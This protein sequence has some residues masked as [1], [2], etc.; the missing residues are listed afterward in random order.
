MAFA[1]A[2]L[3]LCAVAAIAALWPLLSGATVERAGD[4]AREAEIA[5]LKAALAENE[6]DH[7]AGRIT[8]DDAQAARAELGRRL[9]ALTRSEK[10]AATAAPGAARTRRL[11]V[12]AIAAL[13]VPL[14]AIGLYAALGSP[15]LPD[16]PI[17]SR[18]RSPDEMDLPTLIA[19][20]EAHLAENPDDARGWTSLA[21]VYRREGRLA[22]S[23]EA[24]QRA[25]PQL[26]GL[27]RSLALTEIV[28]ITA[29]ETNG[30]DE[31]GQAMLAEAL[32]IAPDNSKADFLL[33][34]AREI[35]A[36]DEERLSEWRAL[37]E[38]H[39]DAPAEWLPLARQRIASLSARLEG[40]ASVEADIARLPARE[41]DAMIADMVDGLAARLANDPDDAEG[42]LRL[43]RSYAV[44]DRR[45]DAREAIA[46]ARA[47]FDGDDAVSGRLAALET[48]LG[49]AGT[50]RA[51]GPS[52]TE[53]TPDERTDEPA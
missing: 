10:E 18:E 44:L 15:A 16:R 4:E 8:F 23:R 27:N 48:E 28:E 24:W 30:I 22:D 17:A 5:T 33:V 49:L 47:T 40:T 45:D 31:R 37:V 13:A 12:P 1:L 43:I 21:P 6:R 26:A 29:I 35:A 34:A 14:G 53:A 25:L 32:S 42:W 38:R 46:S 51:T 3:L 11:L 52:D 7:E 36:D 41:R 39:R 19:R 20:I 50:R 9:L 2:T